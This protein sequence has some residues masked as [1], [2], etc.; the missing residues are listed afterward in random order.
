MKK[1]QYFAAACGVFLLL[2]SACGQEKSNEFAG[3]IE[4]RYVAI[5]A[6]H[7]GKLMTS[8][9]EGHNVDVGTALF[10]LDDGVQKRALQQA[11]AQ[12]AQAQAVLANLQSG[13]RQNKMDALNARLQAAQADADYAQKEWH[14]HQKL[15]L[16]GAASRSRV[17]AL[18]RQYQMASASV[19]TIQAEIRSASV[20]ARNQQI[21]AAVA[22]LQVAQVQ[23]DEA[24]FQLEEQIQYSPL[25]GLVY[26]L[27]YETGEY[28]PPGRAVVQLLDMQRR[29]VYFFV[30]Q[31]HLD[32]FHIGQK[33][34]VRWDT[35][36]GQAEKS[37]QAHIV[38]ISDV[39]EYT[40]PVIFSNQTRDNLVYLL[41]AEL[42]NDGMS[43]PKTGQPVS[44]VLP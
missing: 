34:L 9:K 6:P 43:L 31:N 33:V 40:P 17:D 23:K 7:G 37:T 28:V 18:R 1:I 22:S 14:R 2:L 27:I 35:V 39:A 10:A 26:R 8:V 4:G 21:Q 5:S 25:Q 44:V 42:I 11:T 30:N 16:E 12:V 15:L 38:Y 36:Q 41:K 19:R 24:Q 3:Y 32:S 13:A 20:G 29:K